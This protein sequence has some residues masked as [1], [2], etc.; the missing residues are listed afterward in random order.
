MGGNFSSRLIFNFLFLL[1]NQYFENQESSWRCWRGSYK[2][3]LGFPRQW[4]VYSSP[5]SIVIPRRCRG[6]NWYPG[7]CCAAQNKHS[8][9]WSITDQMHQGR[10]LTYEWLN[11]VGFSEILQLL[12]FIAIF[13]YHK[14][15]YWSYSSPD[16]PVCFP[17]V[18]EVYIG[19]FC[20]G[21]NLYV[22]I[23]FIINIGL[24]LQAFGKTS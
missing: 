10:K 15:N 20:V 13:M 11:S 23:C 24:L 22:C 18:T 5:A 17:G 16:L 3:Q 6:L 12:P 8:P 21:I 2:L 14:W 1:G 19:H 9:P 7:M 4:D